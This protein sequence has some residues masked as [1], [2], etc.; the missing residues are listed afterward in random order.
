MPRPFRSTHNS[1]LG[2]PEA[3]DRPCNGRQ[4]RVAIHCRGNK[5]R[6]VGT[7]LSSAALHTIGHDHA[8]PSARGTASSGP[9]GRS[10]AEGFIGVTNRRSYG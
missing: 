9:N 3:R 1:Q 5:Q 7:V 6:Q 4:E 2:L 10:G 8:M